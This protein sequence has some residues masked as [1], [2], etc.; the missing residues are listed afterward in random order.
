MQRIRGGFLRFGDRD[1]KLACSSD[2]LCGKSATRPAQV[3]T[4]VIPAVHEN[5]AMKEI[6]WN[7]HNLTT[8]NAVG[9][10]SVVERFPCAKIGQDEVSRL[11]KR[12]LS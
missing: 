12:S 11:W 9:G 6:P 3:G 1:G 7:S 2:E 4:V 8:L 5:T 10:K